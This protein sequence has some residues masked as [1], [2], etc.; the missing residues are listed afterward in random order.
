MQRSLLVRPLSP[1]GL[2]YSGRICYQ[3]DLKTVVLVDGITCG[4]LA[5]VVW[6]TTN[7]Y[8]LVDLKPGN[9]GLVVHPL[10]VGRS[11]PTKRKIWNH[12]DTKIVEKTSP[13]GYQTLRPIEITNTYP[14]PPPPH[15]HKHTPYQPSP[16]LSLEFD[17]FIK[18]ILI[19]NVLMRFLCWIK[20]WR[21]WIPPKRRNNYPFRC[22]SM[23]EGKYIGYIISTQK[24]NLF[25]TYFDW[26]IDIHSSLTW[27]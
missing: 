6:Q 19:N 8:A 5:R 9:G 11:V 18:I 10:E 15:T 17:M 12:T 13:L 20:Y 14:Y 7:V 1:S 21:I 24:S 16:C 22:L 3:K 25:F 27:L 23:N 26:S 4:D 2:W